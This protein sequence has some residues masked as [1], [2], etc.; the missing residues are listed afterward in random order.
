MRTSY[1]S[2]NEVSEVRTGNRFDNIN[3]MVGIG[4]RPL[5]NL[6]VGY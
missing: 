3:G 2:W 6:Q 5:K 4:L 1:R